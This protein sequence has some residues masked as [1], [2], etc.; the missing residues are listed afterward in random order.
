MHTVHYKANY[1]IELEITIQLWTQTKGNQ[2]TTVD[3]KKR[4]VPT[5]HNRSTDGQSGNNNHAN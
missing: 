3:S 4:I 1:I 2:E 5:T